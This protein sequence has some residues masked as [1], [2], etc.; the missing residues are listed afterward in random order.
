[1]KSYN[2][3]FEKI[4]NF[5]NFITAAKNTQ[6]GKRLRVSTSNFNFFMEKELLKLQGELLDQTYRPG[7]YRQFYVHEP[8]KKIN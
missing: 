5:E 8:K 2:Y 7:K 3:L 4:V 1:M 6:K